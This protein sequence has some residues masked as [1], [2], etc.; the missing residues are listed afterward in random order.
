MAGTTTKTVPDIFQSMEYGPA[1][2]P[3]TATAQAW[4]DHHSRVLGLFIDGKFVRPADRQ[5]RSLMDSRGGLVCST[6]CAVE[7][8][9]SQCASSALKGFEAWSGMS[10]YQRSKVLL[11]LASTLGQHGQCLTELCDLCQAPISSSTLVRMLQYY[12]SW[13]QLRD[14]LIANWMP[15]GVVAVVVS[16]DCTLYS[17]FLKVLPALAM[18]NAV[19]IVPGQSTA[20][21]VLLV[22]QLFTAAGVPAGALSVLTG[23]DMSLAADV[24]QNPSISYVTYSGNKQDGVNLCK[25]TAGMGVPVSVSPNIGAT[26]PIIIF[27]SADINSALDDVIETVFKKKKEVHWVL[28]VQE[29][30]LDS[31]VARLQMRMAGLKCV[32]LPSNDARLLVDT[33]VQDAQHKGAKLM[34]SCAVP[35]AGA[36]YPPT[37]LC[38]VA[39]S[40][41]CVVTPPPGPLLPL[42]TF[43]SNTEAVTLGN[44]SPHGQAASIWTEDLTLALETA[45]SLSVG[46]V[47]VNSHPLSD[48]CLPFS[49]H[50]D[51]GTCTDGGQEG[52]YHFLRPYNTCALPRASP[53]AIDYAKFGTDAP[54][55]I[56]PD[57]TA[58]TP[59]S[60]S[61]FVGGKACKAESGCSMAVYPQG[62]G[63]VLGYCP[64]GGQKDVRNAVEAAIKVQPGWMK[65]SPSA[66]AQSI[67][68]LAKGLEGKRKDIAS[69]ISNQTG[70]PME[71]ADME[72][73]LS[74]AR[75][76]DW[77]AYCD[78]IRGGTLPVPQSGS[79]F[80]IT[81]ALGVIGVVLPD[82][83]PLLSMVTV[84]GAAVSTGNAIIMVP[85]EKYPLPALTFIQVLQSS[86]LP[87]GLVSIIPGRRDQLTK[88]LANHSVIKAIWYWGN[89]EGCQYL[90]YTCTNPLKTLR[91]F[92]QTDKDGKDS[93]RDWTHA[94]V[95]EEMWRNA[96][97]WK[98]V[99][100]PTA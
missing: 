76:S 67:Q 55:V 84:L 83:Q 56:I 8:D 46:S 36:Q 52:L 47:W 62:G 22:A 16:D 35:S 53:L 32:A 5:A 61:Q 94:C 68:S 12:S 97:Q 24:A 23:S 90:Q 95:L 49:G 86:D 44:H 13:A 82:K 3:N 70:L 93:S 88:A 9:I 39:P 42:M 92:C 37:V 26:C 80:S 59:K 69:S 64:D 41:P 60:Y 72:V 19:I 25:A 6:V 63:S 85:S 48:P 58:G 15:L 7:A 1:S 73:E 79:G 38:G 34:P 78:K 21:P 100:I 65:K 57:D 51:S 91:L 71:E 54:Q 33:A 89:H 14:T 31:V 11:R 77:A 75:L 45:K 81:E 96:V 17:L 87:A 43:R 27:E 40:S 66:R 18:G 29:S 99:W 10:C 2:S 20:A 74:I 4:L 98:S 50:K 28:C 30:V